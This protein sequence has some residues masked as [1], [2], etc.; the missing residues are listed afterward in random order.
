MPRRRRDFAQA[1]LSGSWLFDNC[2]KRGWEKGLGDEYS[3]ELDTCFIHRVY[4]VSSKY[5]QRDMGTF[6][7]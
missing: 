5:L 2:L 6:L 4:D 1:T 3:S 7:I